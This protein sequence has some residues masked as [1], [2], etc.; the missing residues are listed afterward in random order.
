MHGNSREGGGGWGK[1]EICS[2]SGDKEV[3]R[4]AGWEGG[5]DLIYFIYVCVHVCFSD[6]LACTRIHV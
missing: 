4:N 2:V 5:A 6:E 3:G 1:E